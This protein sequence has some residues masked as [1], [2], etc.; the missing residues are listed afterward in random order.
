MKF[1]IGEIKR[2]AHE[3]P[4]PFQGEVHV[5]ELEN[6]NNDIRKIDPLHVEGKYSI[7]EDE[8]I[9]SFTIKGKMILPCARTLV[10]VPYPF[11]IK[12]DEVFSLSPYYGEKEMEDDI[13]QVEGEEID[14]KPYVMEN[15]VLHIPFR[16]FTD[17]EEAY[18][19]AAFKGEGWEFISP[20]EKEKTIDPRME[21]LQSFFSDNEKEK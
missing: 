10:D 2:N 9:F 17:D 1:T 16:V 15:V 3:K 6:M 13:H 12:A 19:Q 8:I 14:L 18:K 7:H 4:Y 11:Q 20:E 21:K 5:D